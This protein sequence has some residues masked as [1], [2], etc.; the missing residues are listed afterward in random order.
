MKKVNPI[1]SWWVTP[2]LPYE[3]IFDYPL[4]MN[5][6][7]FAK[8][9]FLYSR[10]FIHPLKRRI[11]KWYL[12]RLQAHTGLVVIGVT[13]SAGKSSTVQ[14]LSSILKRHGKTV[15]TPPSI[16]PIYN[17]PNTILK[18]T[19]ETK[20]L[21]LEMSVEYPGEMDYYLWLARPKIG[22]I[23][24][25]YPTHVEFLGDVAGVLKEKRKL[26]KSLGNDGIAVLNK[27]DQRLRSLSNKLNAKIVWFDGE[28]EDCAT[29]AARV[30]GVGEKDIASG[31][32]SYSPPKHRYEIIKSKSGAVIFDDSYNSNPEALLL[33]LKKFAKLAGSKPKIAVLG[34]M[35]ELGK[36]AESEHKRVGSE[37]KRYGF[38]KVFG[39]GKLM[40]YITENTFDSW[41]AVLPRV[42]MF[43]K[44][45]YYI[46]V[47]GSR[48]IALDKL[49]EKLV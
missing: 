8:F 26:V 2:K 33:T 14:M 23:T 48:S 34:D 49:V 4:L 44:P 15:A 45:D 32:K 35:L 19:S 17:V 18:C 43:L 41:E 40:K 5:K 27:N 22:V 25:I 36:I 3:D 20:F 24:N 21:I 10:W 31:L 12:R 29:S 1:I 11:A 30:L 7:L 42:K 6:N 46:L 47:K 28:N 16:D 13:G 9:A 39:V 38:V 37:V